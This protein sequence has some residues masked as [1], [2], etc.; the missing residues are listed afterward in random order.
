MKDNLPRISEW[1]FDQ[2]D[3]VYEMCGHSFRA[4]GRHIGCSNHTFKKYYELAKKDLDKVEDPTN[5]SHIVLP[6]SAEVASKKTPK[7]TK[8]ASSERFLDPNEMKVALFDIEATSLRGDFGMVL[9]AVVKQYGKDDGCV[10]KLDFSNPDLLDAERQM[11]NEIKDYIESFDGVIGY[12]SSKYDM[13]MLRTRMLYHGIKPI[14]KCKHLDLYF[15]IKRHVNTTSRRMERVADLMRV[16]SDRLL[17]E[18]TKLDINEWIRV[19]NG[20][21]EKSLDYIVQ[22]CICDVEILEGILNQV[23]DF[24]PDRIM[25][26]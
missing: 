20:R 23:K 19:A 16:N 10:F 11:L 3:R 22:H 9:C 21:D 18:K 17:P 8:S 1:S 14:P 6:V 12:F 4:A 13:P 25:R 24:V 5:D 2:L 15:T 7:I 26:M